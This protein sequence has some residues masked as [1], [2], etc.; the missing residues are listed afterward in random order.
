MSPHTLL[1]P[2]QASARASTGLLALRL[3]IGIGLM[4][5]GWPKIQNPL[6]WMGSE[7]APHPVLQ[8]IAAVSEFVGGLG[9]ATGFLTPLA[10]IGVMSTMGYAIM[11][12]V[13][14]GEP[15]FSLKAHSW[16]LASLYLCGAL[17][18]LAL[19]PG[20]LSLDALVWRRR[21]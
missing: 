12:H 7:G 17:A 5:H 1:A 3:A 16:E 20:R 8:A 11:T 15:Y 10:A 4:H 21:R 13:S 14:K 9:L 6:H 18:L 19:G 2:P